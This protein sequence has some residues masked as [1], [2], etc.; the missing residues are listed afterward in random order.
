MEKH[1]ETRSETQIRKSVLVYTTCE[2]AGQVSGAYL[3]GEASR[4][5]SSDF[6][7]RLVKESHDVDKQWI[8]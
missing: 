5:S 8:R 2:D 7:R 4:Y 1:C 6:I 3:K